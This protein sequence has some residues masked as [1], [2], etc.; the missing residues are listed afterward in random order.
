[1]RSRYFPSLLAVA[2][3][4][5]A[6]CG[7]D[8]PSGPILDVSLRRQPA[9]GEEVRLLANVRG[10]TLG[11]ASFTHRFESD[12]RHWISAQL[13]TTRPVGFCFGE[14]LA[15]PLSPARTD[16]MYVMFGSI[17]EGAIC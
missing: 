16:S 1:M 2:T 14:L 11:S 6:A 12:R 9:V 15:I 7:S 8:D 5:V 10:D 17:P 13:D 4:V 3:S